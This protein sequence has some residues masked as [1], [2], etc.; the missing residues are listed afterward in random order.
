[1]ESMGLIA[2]LVKVLLTPPFALSIISE[3]ACGG[4]VTARKSGWAS[5][6]PFGVTPTTSGLGLFVLRSFTVDPLRNCAK[7]REIFHFLVS[8]KKRDLFRV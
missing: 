3:A 1:M 4:V 5:S 7:V 6:R 8:Y 2:D